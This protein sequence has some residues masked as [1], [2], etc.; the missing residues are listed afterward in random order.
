MQT[1]TKLQISQGRI[2]SEAS[3]GV[4][5]KRF[6]RKAHYYQTGLCVARVSDA[7]ANKW[8]YA[9]SLHHGQKTNLA[10]QTRQPGL[11]ETTNLKRSRAP[12]LP[13]LINY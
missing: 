6:S 4:K 12:T 2:F 7:S 10:V 3:K 13:F 11:P 9:Y 1:K 5:G 8:L